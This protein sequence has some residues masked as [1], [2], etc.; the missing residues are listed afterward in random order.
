M[1][2]CMDRSIFA[3]CKRSKTRGGD[4]RRMRLVDRDVQ[5]IRRSTHNK[6]QQIHP[7]TWYPP[8]TLFGET[9]QGS[10]LTQIPRILAQGHSN[11]GVH[12][13]LPVCV[14][15][16]NCQLDTQNSGECWREHWSGLRRMT[17]CQHTLK[18]SLNNFRSV[19]GAE[20]CKLSSN[21]MTFK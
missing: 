1:S 9:K 18:R 7:Q 19:Y 17:A 3:C 13:W 15:A 8:T 20:L 16:V 5:Q 10:L 21:C 12:C 14:W 6:H 4:G 11:Y 2:P